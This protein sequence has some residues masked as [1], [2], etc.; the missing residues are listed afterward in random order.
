M[1][2]LEL[3]GKVDSC[4][5]ASK[6]IPSHLPSFEEFFGEHESMHLVGPCSSQSSS[7]APPF[8]SSRSN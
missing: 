8:G 7:R 1:P 4:R 2:R 6:S 5:L 3:D